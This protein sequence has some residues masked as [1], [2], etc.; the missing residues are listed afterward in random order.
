MGTEAG[1]TRDAIRVTCG[2]PSLAL[3]HSQGGTDR[4]QRERRYAIVG[5]APPHRSGPRRLRDPSVAPAVQ[6][7]TLRRRATESERKTVE[8]AGSPRQS[9]RDAS[10]S[11]GLR[12]PWFSLNTASGTGD[13]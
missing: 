2:A 10:Q 13:A 12:R 1:A 5:R 8:S 7:E 4:W 9:V 11:F 6:L 3:P